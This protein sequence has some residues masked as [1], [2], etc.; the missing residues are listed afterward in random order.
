LLKAG[1]VAS[2]VVPPSFEGR[3]IDLKDILL[4]LLNKPG[5]IELVTR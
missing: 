5:G 4:K 1:V 2:G 3:N